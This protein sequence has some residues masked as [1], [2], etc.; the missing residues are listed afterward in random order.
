MNRP[1]WLYALLFAALLLPLIVQAQ[2]PSHEPVPP[3][4]TERH[5]PRPLTWRPCPENATI[6]CATLTLPVDY[7][8]PNG[9]TFDMAVA[10]SK[11]SDPRKRIGVVFTNPGGPGIS[12]VDFVMFVAPNVQFFAPYRERFDIISFDPRGVGRSRPLKCAPEPLALPDDRSAA[13]LAAY[14]DGLGRRYAKACLQQDGAFVTKLSTN[15][16]ARDMEMLR[17]ALGERKVTYAAGSYGSQLGAV[18]ASL[19]PQ[20]LR[21]MALDAGI[22]PAFRDNYVEFTT[23][24]LD[25]FELELQRVDVLCRGDAAC[26]LRATG[27]VAAFDH[28]AAQLNAAPYTTPDGRVLTGED[29]T[30][31]VYSLLYNEQRAPVIVDVLADGLA[32]DYTLLSELRP[33]V[34]AGL[35]S[36]IYAIRCNDYGTRRRAA[37]Y[38][39]V[40]EVVGARHPRFFGRF[41]LAYRLATCSAWPAADPPIIRNVRRQVDIPLLLI[42]NDFDPAT[43]PAF[44][45]NLANALGMERSVFRYAGGGHTFPKDDA[46]VSAVFAAYLFDRRLPV[47]GASCPGQ[48]ISFAPDASAARPST[49]RR[50]QWNTV[51]MLVR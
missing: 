35:S 19:F 17:R 11:A 34:D 24:Q 30:E 25:G 5:Q 45:R 39:P 42:M 22:D 13:S 16:V 10:R 37:E 43:P 47:E 50:E 33:S 15:N 14:F 23:S 18:Y 49:V 1:R 27:V 6:D 51:G 28:V 29:V 38:L 44:A 9:D 41:Y 20:R 12:G 3:D 8:K 36:A 7:D 32:G 48:S 26:R 21:A 46:C 40:D 31:V 4:V 2:T